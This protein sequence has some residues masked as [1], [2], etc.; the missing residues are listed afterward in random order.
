M[1]TFP[2]YS[3]VA[4]RRQLW[5]WCRFGPARNTRRPKPEKRSAADAF[6]TPTFFTVNYFGSA[7]THTSLERG[8]FLSTK[9]DLSRAAPHITRRRAR[10]FLTCASSIIQAYLTY[11]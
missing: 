8:E 2:E 1:R 7:S 9:C 4:R 5:K 11:I 6:R 3:R 10:P